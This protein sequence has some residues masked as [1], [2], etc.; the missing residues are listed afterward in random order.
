MSPQSRVHV[1][2]QEAQGRVQAHDVGEDKRVAEGGASL[3]G[4]V[5]G[6][7]EE[8]QQNQE[9]RL[10]LHGLSMR[11]CCHVKSALNVAVSSEGH[12]VVLLCQDV[13]QKKTYLR[14]E[15]FQ[16]SKGE[17]EN[18]EGQ[19]QASEVPLRV[20]VGTWT[21]WCQSDSHFVLLVEEAV[22]KLLLEC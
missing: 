12:L 18:P 2:Q 3:P 8:Q 17:H 6:V 15:I 21:D 1:V 10:K 14:D 22:R 16:R 19:R 20:M 13:M 5:G 11:Q 4:P 9:S 7:L